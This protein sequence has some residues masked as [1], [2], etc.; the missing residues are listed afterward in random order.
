MM[1]S[2]R[3]AFDLVAKLGLDLYAQHYI[4]ELDEDGNAAN[5]D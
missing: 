4:G 2:P 5:I 1:M 3:G